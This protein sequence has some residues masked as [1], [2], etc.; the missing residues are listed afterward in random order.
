VAEY[1]AEDGRQK[2]NFA[3]ITEV[4]KLATFLFKIKSKL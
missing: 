1:K 2:I 3:Q 4:I